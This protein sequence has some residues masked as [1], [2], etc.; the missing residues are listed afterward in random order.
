M[1]WHK[2]NVKHL[3]MT[4]AIF[5]EISLSQKSAWFLD[6]CFLGINVSVSDNFDKKNTLTLVSKTKIFM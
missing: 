1:M 5:R 4:A 3:R 2:A 6:A